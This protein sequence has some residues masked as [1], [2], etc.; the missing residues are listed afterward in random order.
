MILDHSIRTACTVCAAALLLT[1][2]AVPEPGDCVDAQR[3][4]SLP[5]QLDETSGIVL[6]R[7]DPNIIWAH[8]DSESTATLYA[9]D[10]SGRL[11]A[12]IAL[13]AAGTQ[14]DWEDIAAGPCPMGE[15]LYIGDIGDNVH[16][17]DDRAILR[18]AEP[19]IDSPGPVDLER[20][21]IRYPDGPA[22]AEALF[23]MPDTS[24]YI[25]T[26]G[27]RL[28]V[29]V[30]RYPPPLRANERVMLERV[31]QLSDGVAQL[32]D[33]VTGADA[34]PDGE[35]IAMRTYTR[36]AMFRFDGDTLVRLSD[37]GSDITSLGEP[38][39]EAIAIAAG[40]TLLLATE[41]GPVH[42]QPFLASVRCPA[43]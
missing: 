10:R 29:S 5:A 34:S 33:L 7:R 12:E 9:L 35:R 40:D 38:Q 20:Y 1:A 6:S 27:R 2:C 16:D 23:V 11:L 30:Y 24:V 17:R 28:G 26:K 32:P 31:Q 15:C 37:T 8:N 4:A 3:I 43:P 36:V 18:I 42:A 14:F 22:D 13:P 39:G 19:R 21:P 41:A 25:I